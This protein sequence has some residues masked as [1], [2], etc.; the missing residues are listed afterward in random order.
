MR[1]NIHH[2]YLFALALSLTLACARTPSSGPSRTN[3][4]P[5]SQPAPVTVLAHPA[6]TQVGG[7][8]ANIADIAE[9]ATPSVVNISL[10]KLA[11]VRGQMPFPFFFGPGQGPDSRERR[12][13]GMGS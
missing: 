7:A 11:K 8:S 2:P 9:R 6:L 12:E 5:E 13:Q 4:T 1:T 3:V 10:T